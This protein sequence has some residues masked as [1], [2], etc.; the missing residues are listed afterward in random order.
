MKKHK[1]FLSLALLFAS[2]SF[3]IPKGPCDKKEVCCE[4]PEPG[5]F[6]FYYPKDMNLSCPQ[7][8]YV[9]GEFLLM[10]VKEEGLEYAITQNITATADN[11]NSF[12]LTGGDIQ[13]YSTGHRNWDWTCG[14]RAGLGFY[15]NHDCFNA[16]A[17]WTY[18]RIN[19][20]SGKNVSG[21]ALLPFWLPPN[22]AI[23]TR[24]GI[25]N[26]AS[27]AR[28]T[29]NIN[30]LDLK[31]GK[32]YHISRYV[33]FNPHCGLRIAWIDQDYTSRNGGF[34]EITAPPPGIDDTDVVVKNKNDFWGVG[35]RVGIDT[36]WHFGAGWYL[37][38]KA[39]ASLLY[40][41]FDIF[42]DLIFDTDTFYQLKHDFYTNSPNMEIIF[43]LC[44]S[45]L[46]SKNKYMVSLKAAYEMH[47]WW[48]QNRLRRFFDKDTDFLAVHNDISASSSNDE[49]ARGDLT[50]NGFSFAIQ[51][52]F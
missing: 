44:W 10:Q 1:I 23:G 21:G 11:F 40:S 48:D 45:H 20:D 17:T 47:Q 19:N 14:V 12:P 13:G 2:I 39:S 46:F 26:I 29:G 32:P 51:F 35:P 36:E 24:S 27:S 37:F 43:G 50:V 49:V 42:Q 5:P 8:F 28:W 4:E 52:D 18:I 41:H 34:F 25:P 22:L 7:G 6:A 31:L 15:L 30:T 33:I 16:E 3:A 9:K 38:G